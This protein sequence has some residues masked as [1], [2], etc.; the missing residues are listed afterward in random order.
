MNIP[1]GPSPFAQGANPEECQY[2]SLLYNVMDTGTYVKDR[3]GVGCLTK[4]GTSMR[5]SLRD[6]TLP[7]FTTKKVF[8][9]GVVEELRWF[10]RGETS[11]KSLNERGVKIWDGNATR[12]FLDMNGFKDRDEGDLGPIYGFQWRHFGAPYLRS[13]VD[14]TGM[15]VDQIAKL[16]E[17][18]R[19]NPNSR[20][21]ILTAWNPTDI[22]NMALP[23][24]HIL[25][26][27]H[28]CHG[29]LSC[30]LYQR[31]ADLGLGVPFNVASYS[32]LT[33]LIA[34]FT[35]LK[36]GEFIHVMGNTHIYMNHIMSL[37]EQM[38]RI[39]K[40]FPKL[41]IR[42]SARSIDEWQ[43]SDLELEGYSPH[44]PIP[45]ALAI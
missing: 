41:Y 38:S 22:G 20:R 31:S 4:F 13:D 33:H 8:F 12:E 23:P 44:P 36:A 35:G 15:G 25:A 43:M 30:L 24:C 6:N 29:E 42:R 45:M 10:L 5:F 37:Q 16:I 26:Q 39:P 9:K 21:H 14:Y 7:L 17:N 28:V 32:L 19:T 2:I 1:Y 11:S 40:A 27:F 3:T 34:K 18:I